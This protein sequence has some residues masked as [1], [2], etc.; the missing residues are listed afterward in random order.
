MKTVGIICEYDP[1]H[2]GHE[3]LIR[4]LRRAGAERVI[5]LMSGDSV[6]RGELAILPKRYRARAAA[7]CG[8]DA[9]FELPYPWCSASAEFFAAA[10]VFL[11]RKL[12]VDTIAFGSE[13]A[14]LP[15]LEAAADRAVRLRNGGMT[16]TGTAEG[17]AERYFAALGLPDAGPNDILGVEYL[18]AARLQG[19][20]VDFFPVRR[21]GAGHGSRE[22]AA[23]PSASFLRERIAAG[24]VPDGMPEAMRAELC[25]AIA[26]GD[27]PVRTD[28]LSAALLAYWRLTDP[29][30]SGKFAECGG[31]VSGR[32]HRAAL[33]A[34][35]AE[36]MLA[37]AAT[38]KYTASRLRRA[39]LFALTG[40]TSEDLR[41][42]PGYVLLL[43][44]GMEGRR[45]LSARRRTGEIPIVTKPSRRPAETAEQRRQGSLSDAMDAIST[46]ARPEPSAAVCAF[47][48][49]IPLPLDRISGE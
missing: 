31:G 44:A 23:Y 37:W 33:R 13:T 16:E 45:F 20:D 7:A 24:E 8:A 21:T 40:V 32:L 12:G 38:K 15:A 35:S 11:L 28:R 42:R 17:T 3:Y 5:C 49:E 10:G 25:A 30:V 47:C 46:L 26:K 34:G 22:A 39:A 18:K 9:V 41:A 36:K 43:A 6:Q 14:D 29:A 27:C 1:F 48:E 19:A 2:S 4:E